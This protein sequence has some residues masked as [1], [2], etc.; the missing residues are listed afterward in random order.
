[1]QGYTGNTT[2]DAW[3]TLI[4]G[5]VGKG[6]EVEVCCFPDSDYPA[7][8]RISTRTG[9]SRLRGGAHD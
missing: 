9:Y 8:F 1:M 3:I 7:K 5:P 2:L 6:L 4:L